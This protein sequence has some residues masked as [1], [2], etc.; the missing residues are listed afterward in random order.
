LAAVLA[1]PLIAEAARTARIPE[2]TLRS[3]LSRPEFAREYA[4]RR[5]EL[6]QSV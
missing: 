5:R 3:W 1:A 4:A 6:L 2:R